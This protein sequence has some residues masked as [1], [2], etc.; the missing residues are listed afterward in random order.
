MYGCRTSVFRLER[1]ACTRR[2]L[3]R[4]AYQVR[5]K[6]CAGGGAVAVG[7]AVTGEIGVVESVERLGPQNHA[8]GL[9]A[10]GALQERRHIVDRAAAAGIAGHHDGVYDWAMGGGA[11]VAAVGDSGGEVVGESGA[12]RGNAAKVNLQRQD[13]DTAEHE[14]VTLV[15]NSVGVFEVAGLQGIVWVLAGDVGIDVVGSMG[16]GEDS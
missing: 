14:A 15:E 11:G 6:A 8:E 7:S 13:V 5:S 16:P 12:E 9:G 10:E 1:A 4:D 3:R 2:K